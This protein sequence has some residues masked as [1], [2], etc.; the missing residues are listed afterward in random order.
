MPKFAANLS[1]LFTE[2]SFLDRFEAAARAGFEAVEFQFPYAWPA[3]AIRERVDANDLEVVRPA[4]DFHGLLPV[5]RV[6]RPS[7]NV[8]PIRPALTSC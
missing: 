1:M 7:R 4:S 6:R 3:D 5:P 8:G 2:V